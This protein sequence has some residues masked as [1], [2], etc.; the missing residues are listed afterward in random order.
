MNYVEALTYIQ[1]F[2]DIERSRDL[3]KAAPRFNLERVHRL[4][5]L[6]GRPQDRFKSIH[7]TG[8]K[9]KGSTAAMI[10]SVLRAAGQR[11]GLFTSP[12][13][14]S[15]VERIA[16]SGDFIAEAELAALTARLAPLVDS[17][18]TEFR[19]L[20]TLTTFEVTTAIAL[21]HF[22]AKR[23]DFAVL[24]VG[25]GG[26]LDATNVV[27]PTVAIIT[28][29]S[30][31]HTR[32]LGDTLLQIAGEKAG[33]IKPGTAVVTAPQEP[34]VMALIRATCEEK[35]ARL[36]GVGRDLTWRSER[37]A[38]Q[39]VV[40]VRG[41]L[42]YYP[43]LGLSLVGGH[44]AVNAVVAL[45]AIEVLREQGV[46][47]TQEHVRGGFQSVWWPGRLETIALEPRVVVDGAH[48][49]D[50]MRKLG[51]A[52]RE[53]FAYRRLLVVLGASLDKDVGGMVDEIAPLAS[54]FIATR[55][56]HPRSANTEILAAA[57]RKHLEQVYEVPDVAAGLQFARDLA[58]KDD[59]ICATGSLF[60]VAE[61][62]EAMG[63]TS[64]KSRLE[65]GG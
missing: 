1:S 63:L 9:G 57:A 62:R 33:I 39:E 46:L 59:L 50:S 23:V 18:H 65:A 17:V 47:V 40:S 21:E 41:R 7:I 52:L 16:V 27:T 54:V 36:V 31:D 5:D 64:A 14:H 11:V 8:T 20:G 26:R 29:I 13:L 34:E 15:F 61:A 6:A 60:I 53:N 56:A 2:S 32:F 43:R 4:L 51:A 25:M 49:V 38:G 24:E 19:E 12:H 55:S 3:T 48:N 42:G 30:I 45:A 37:V 28:S 35:R 22:A 58:E 10:D 44:Q